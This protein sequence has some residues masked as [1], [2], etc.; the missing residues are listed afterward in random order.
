MIRSPGSVRVAT[1]VALGRRLVIDA[2]TI[3]AAASD[4]SLSAP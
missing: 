3:E 2:P 4:V 1:A